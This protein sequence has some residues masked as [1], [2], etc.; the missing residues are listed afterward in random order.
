[1]KAV[2]RFEERLRILMSL[3]EEDFEGEVG[4]KIRDELGNIWDE[5]S[6]DEK[7]AMCTLCEDLMK[8]RAK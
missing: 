2:E 4:D 7:M 3:F 8:M 5:M 6:A 1:M